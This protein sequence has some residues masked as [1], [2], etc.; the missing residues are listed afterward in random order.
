MKFLETLF[1]FTT[2]V[3]ALVLAAVFTPWSSLVPPAAA[4]T[5][6]GDCDGGGAVTV[7]EI[8]TMVNIAL[9]QS[10]VDDC[11]RGDANNDGQITV[12]EIVSATNNA[13]NGCPPPAGCQTTATVTVSLD[14]D[15]NATV[16]IAG[17]ELNLDYSPALLSI[18]GTGEDPSVIERVTDITN[19]FGAAAVVDID[20][21]SNGADDRIRTVYLASGIPLPIGGFETVQFDCEPGSRVPVPSDFVCDVPLASDQSGLPIENVECVVQVAVP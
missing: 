3:L 14:F 15:P 2:P 5:C 1:R 17:L 4:Q 16:P 8:I 11:R 20:T 10:Q 9:G 7:D 6:V 13:L 21:D 19:A 12:D 18:P